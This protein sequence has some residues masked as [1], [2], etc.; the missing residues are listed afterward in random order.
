[1][2]YWIVDKWLSNFPYK[3]DLSWWIFILAGIIAFIIAIFTVS[4][5]SWRAATETR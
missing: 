4:W 1:V 2:A 3:V 5:Q